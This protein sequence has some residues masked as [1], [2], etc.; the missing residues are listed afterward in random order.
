[1]RPGEGKIF[2]VNDDRSL[3]VGLASALII[4][5][6]SDSGYAY[7]KRTAIERVPTLVEAGVRI[8]LLDGNL[9]GDS[10]EAADGIE[11]N[12]AIKAAH[13]DAVKTVGISAS[14]PIPDAD[15][16]I[17]RM[18]NLANVVEAVAQL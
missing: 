7:D 16:P 13:G 17:V 8:V 12:A 11:I 5:G 9:D 4:A 18:N 15:V 10:Y 1:M 2:I 3:V 14:D 6:Y